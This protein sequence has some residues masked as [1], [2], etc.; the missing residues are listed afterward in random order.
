MG[1]ERKNLY[2]IFMDTVAYKL[3]R[4]GLRV[5]KI[6]KNKKKPQYNVYWFE[7]TIELHD[8]IHEVLDNK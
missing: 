1:E 7:D 3:E 2:P 4:A 5:I 8:I 6:T